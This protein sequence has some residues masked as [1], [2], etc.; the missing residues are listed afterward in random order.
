M[1]VLYLYANT[2]HGRLKRFADGLSDNGFYGLFRLRAY[3]IR[4]DFSEIE[5]VYP[6]KWCSFVRAKGL[7]VYVQHLPVFWKLFDSDIIFHISSFGTQLLWILLGIRKQKWVLYDYS[8]TG[9][10]G[11]GKTF[12]QKVLRFIIARSAGIITI[13]E[14]EAEL[15]RDLFPHLKD[16][17]V[18][19]PYGTDLAYY[20]PRA[21]PEEDHIFVVGFDSGRDFA[22]VFKAVEG[23]GIK[24]VVTNSRHVR[25]LG[26]LP[27]YVEAKDISDADM[28]DA[29]AKAKIIIIPLDRTGG[30]NDAMGVSVI[31]E[32]MAMGKAV[33]ATDTPTT[34]SYIVQ[35]VNGI[36]VKEKSASDLRAAILNLWNDGQ[37]RGD[38]GR[39]AHTQMCALCSADS[40]AR[41]MSDF[42][43]SLR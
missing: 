37:L 4:T 16:R 42:F 12:K 24:V 38:L 23:L 14:R 28:R 5:Q 11:S 21:V 27:S 18:F 10:L 41:Q 22:T 8:L 3:G 17:I 19:I 36:L 32:S 34:E 2:I 29:Y 1:K 9:W 6:E 26:A 31:V 13:S 7:N 43:T 15:L 35:G 25:K 40:V 30:F 39:A 33:I 20:Q